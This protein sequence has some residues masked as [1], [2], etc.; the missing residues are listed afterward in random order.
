[1]RRIKIDSKLNF[2]EHVRILL[3]KANKKLTAL[4]RAIP[5]LPSTILSFCRSLMKCKQIWLTANIFINDK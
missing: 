5:S 4:A 1:M 2:D 3:S